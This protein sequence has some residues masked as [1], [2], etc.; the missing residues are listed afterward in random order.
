MARRK[1]NQ[2]TVPQYTSFPCYTNRRVEKKVEKK[3]EEKSPETKTET[4]TET[5]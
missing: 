2:E 1:A 3:V 5:K 4:K